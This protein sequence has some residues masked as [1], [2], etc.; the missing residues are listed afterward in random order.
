MKKFFTHNDIFED[1]SSFY[2]GKEKEYEQMLKRNIGK[3]L[4]EEDSIVLNFNLKLYSSY[5]GFVCSDL[6]LIKKDYSGYVVIEI[7]IENHSIRTH[8]LPQIRKLVSCNYLLQSS[9]I[10][11]HLRRVNNNKLNKK[12]FLKMMNEHEANFC[13]ISNRYSAEWDNA[14]GKEGFD[15]VAVTPYLNNES[16]FAFYVK[17]GNKKEGLEEFDIQWNKHC[18]VLKDK[19]RSKLRINESYDVKVNNEIFS[20]YVNNDEDEYFLYPSGSIRIQDVYNHAQIESMKV[21]RYSEEYMEIVL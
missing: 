4:N 11:D 18:F 20:F 3:I 7:E 6:L 9:K 16:E 10:F 17:F 1:H 15:F 2:H 14:L 5:G 12:K 13:V 21:L 19:T 8:V